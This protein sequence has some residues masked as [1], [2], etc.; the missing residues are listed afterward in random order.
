MIPHPR[1]ASS[2]S[3]AGRAAALLLVAAVWLPLACAAPDRSERVLPE[4]TG[5][6]LAPPPNAGSAGLEL[7]TIHGPLSSVHSRRTVRPGADGAFRFEPLPLAAA[8]GD[9]DSYKLYLRLVGAGTQDRVLWRARIARFGSDAPIRLAC[10]PERPLHTGEPCRVTN[11]LAQPWLIDEGRRH[12]LR[13]CAECHG[14]DARGSRASSAGAG[15]EATTRPPD[16]TRIAARHGGRF[17]HDAVAAWI[18]GRSLPPSH[19]RG[20]MPVWGERLSIVFERYAAGDELIGATLDPI[21]A[22][23][24]SIQR[25]S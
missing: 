17:D 4:I 23:L 3:T 11:P 22:Y 13:L 7:E 15:A 25:G 10:D 21:I 24:E 18:E 2:T 6:L 16:L 19:A 12:Y 5:M 14:R 1:S 8:A 9:R 20:G